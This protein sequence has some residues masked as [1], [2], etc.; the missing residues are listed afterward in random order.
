M[1]DVVL[2]TENNKFSPS[3]MPVWESSSWKSRRVKLNSSEALHKFLFASTNID[4][5]SS[6]SGREVSL[7]G[8]TVVLPA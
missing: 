4:A 3:Q 2:V 8:Y 7:Y 6:S 1:E 5:P